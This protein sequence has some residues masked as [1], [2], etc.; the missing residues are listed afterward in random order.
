MKHLLFVFQVVF[1]S[2][3]GFSQQG[4]NWETIKADDF[5]IK[6]PSNWEI[7]ESGVMGTSFIVFSPVA[8]ETDQFRENVNLHKEDLKG[9]KITL[10]EYAELSERQITKLITEAKVIESVN[11]ES[12]Y[13]I[14]Y[15]GKQG[16]LNLMFTQYYFIENGF[17]YVLTLT[18]EKKEYV[19]Y[20][21][22]GESIMNT[23]SIN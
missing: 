22:L 14:V 5:S 15:S 1:C 9:Q 23:F 17:A 2:F 13:K 21:E 16:V 4:E 18:T 11:K 6:Y 8:S 7:N 3:V 19:E 20:K 10:A 12:F